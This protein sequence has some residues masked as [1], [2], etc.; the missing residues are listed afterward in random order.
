M[1]YILFYGTDN[2]YLQGHVLTHHV[3]ISLFP[4][5]PTLVRVKTGGPEPCGHSRRWRHGRR[6]CVPGT[7]H[8]SEILPWEATEDDGCG[9]DDTKQQPHVGGKT[10]GEYVRADPHALKEAEGSAS[11]P[12]F[13]GAAR[14]LSLATALQQQAPR[15]AGASETPSSRPPPGNVT[16]LKP[17]SWDFLYS[18][19]MRSLLRFSPCVT[20]ANVSQQ[21]VPVSRTV[22][23]VIFLCVLPDGLHCLN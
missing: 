12:S 19:G 22:W 20:V 5:W 10:Y 13:P 17:N 4:L 14:C 7:A 8:P 6:G 15:P 23:I 2:I 3:Q 1:L 21:L 16:H 11:V 18:E 9:A